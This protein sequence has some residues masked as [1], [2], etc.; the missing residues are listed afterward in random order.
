MPIA[1]FV[2]PEIL[3]GMA[4]VYIAERLGLDYH[5]PFL[6]S[7]VMTLVTGAILSLGVG[8]ISFI[9][10]LVSSRKANAVTTNDRL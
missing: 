3:A 7:F 4:A 6:S 2:S 9:I 1:R 8:V 5:Q 10:L